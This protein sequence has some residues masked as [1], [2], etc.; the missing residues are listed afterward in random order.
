MTPNRAALIIQH[1]WWKWYSWQV[2]Q[3]MEYGR[4]SPEPACNY[5]NYYEDYST[6]YE[7]VDY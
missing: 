7:G 3:D 6:C 4:Y 5:N 1:A 2:A